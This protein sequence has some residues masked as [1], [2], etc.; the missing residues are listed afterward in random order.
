MAKLPPKNP[1]TDNIV[2]L[3]DAESRRKFTYDQL[4]DIEATAEATLPAVEALHKAGAHLVVMTPDKKPAFKGW[5][6]TTAELSIIKIHVAKGGPV[7]IVPWSL[8]SVVID[9]DEGGGDDL[10]EAVKRIELEVGARA[11][12]ICDSRKPG[13]AHLWFRATK[14]YGNKDWRCGIAAGELRGDKGSIVCWHPSVLA[15]ALVRREQAE[16]AVLDKLI[17]EA[18]AFNRS[19]GQ[20]ERRAGEGRNKTLN[21]SCFLAGLN[22]SKAALDGAKAKAR[23]FNLPEAEIEATA[24]SGWEAGQVERKEKGLGGDLPLT[25]QGLAK[26]MAGIDVDIRVNTR[27]QRYEIKMPGKPWGELSDTLRGWLWDRLAERYVYAPEGKDPHPWRLRGVMRDDT[28][29]AYLHRHQCDPWIDEYLDLIAP[30][31]KRARIGG[32]LG[33]LFGT[34][35][36]DINYW[37]SAQ[38]FLGVLAR[39]FEPGCQLRESVVLIGGERAGKSSLLS[40]IFPPAL[41]DLVYGD[42][43]QLNAPSQ[44]QAEAM[45]GKAL[46]EVADFAGIRKA[47]IEMLKAFLTRRNDGSVRLAYRRDPVSLPRRCIIVPTTNQ[48][49]PLPN[50]PY[51]NTRFVPVE[52]PVSGNVEGYM[53]K[54]RD[55]LWAE[56]LAI[57]EGDAEAL[58]VWH[59]A[60]APEVLTEAIAQAKDRAGR[61]RMPRGFYAEAGALA[62]AARSADEST[63]E[64]LNNLASDGR[65]TMGQ[66]KQQ[67]FRLDDV[68]PPSQFVLTTALRNLGWSG[69]YCER[70]ESGR[71][72]RFWHGPDYR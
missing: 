23:G 57:I 10:I 43:L 16:P 37:A 46:V 40:E 15:E 30:W 13:R 70:D 58:E 51:G 65:Y 18:E 9:L 48:Q 25:R 2:D 28:F 17:K 22:E 36:S 34:E 29:H 41:R 33:D 66:I 21:H 26:G 68:L 72:G 8:G 69:S 39:T 53:A 3:G 7:G 55:Q 47:D 24:R 11:W 6:K 63:E 71:V 67:C 61:A 31:D 52:I 45:L 38:L 20:K 5:L 49:T 60:G 54:H 1:K 44:R 14:P 35:P 50:D 12:A 4:A 27:A 19:A 42:G 56:A 64:R 59:Q 62:E 32:V